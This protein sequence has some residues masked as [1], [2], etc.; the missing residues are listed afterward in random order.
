M[1]ARRAR[2]S[3]WHRS[4]SRFVLIAADNK[5]AGE[6]AR[7]NWRVEMLESLTRLFSRSGFR[8]PLRGFFPCLTKSPAILHR[9]GSRPV[10]VLRE[11]GKS[12]LAR[13]KWIVGSVVRVSL[14]AGTRPFGGR[15]DGTGRCGV[16]RPTSRAGRVV[17]GS[18]CIRPRTVP[19]WFQSRFEPA[20]ECCSR[21]RW[22]EIQTSSG[23]VTLGFG[24]ALLPF[25]D[26]GQV[27]V[28]DSQGRVEHE[29]PLRMRCRSTSISDGRRAWERTSAKLSISRC[30]RA[31]QIVEQQR[32]RRFIF[33]YIPLFHDCRTYVCAMQATV[34]GKSKLPCY[35]PLKG[36]WQ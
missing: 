28:E 10:P 8:M 25:I 18:D 16:A 12:R 24:S 36:Y 15:S 32:H 29:Y 21:T 34:E 3:S 31:D 33:P 4:P 7:G 20:R 27:T 6:F 5:A 1:S 11:M 23:P 19:R 26:R 17:T 2:C 13:I 22:V 30:A 14:L 9:N 35:A